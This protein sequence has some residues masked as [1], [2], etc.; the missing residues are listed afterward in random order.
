MIGELTRCLTLCAPSG[1][2]SDERAVWL[3]TAWA[4]ISHIP[5]GVFESACA[6]ARKIVDHPS[7]I[8]PAIIK[9]SAYMTD[10]FIRRRN[11]EEAAWRNRNAPRL[12]ASAP[13]P[14]PYAAD[15]DEVS[16]MMA[17]LVASLKGKPVAPD[18][19]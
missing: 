10:L 15:R 8:V 18:D 13:D 16:K 1:M 5:A 3:A 12:E 14:D 4:E 7:K 6:A 11:D 2:S 9:E 19:P 17:D